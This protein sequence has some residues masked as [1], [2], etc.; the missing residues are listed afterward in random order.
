MIRYL[1]LRLVLVS[2][3][4]SQKDEMMSRQNQRLTG[5][6]PENRKSDHNNKDMV[7]PSLTDCNFPL[8]PTICC[9]RE[10]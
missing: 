4:R 7:F 10:H 6:Q 9:L 1:V 2:R 8:R 3:V 5:C